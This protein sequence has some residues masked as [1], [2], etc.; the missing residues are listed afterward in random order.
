MILA[1]FVV[2]AGFVGWNVGGWKTAAKAAVVTAL[3][4]AWIDLA[5]RLLHGQ[6][7]P[8]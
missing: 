6:P 2:A 7:L 4:L 3:L 5:F 1:L 8:W